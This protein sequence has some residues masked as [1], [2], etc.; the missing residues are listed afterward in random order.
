MR[1]EPPPLEG[2]NGIITGY[3]LRYRIQGKKGGNTI[4]TP[5]N[6]R[7]HTLSDLERSTKYQ[8]KLWAMN[9]NGT[10]P[11]TDWFDIET[12]E[13]DLDES[14]VPDEPGPLRGKLFNYFTTG[15]LQ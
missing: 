1:W 12:Y 5:A 15:C 3:K 10:G 14:R 8:V 6:T 11:P 7:M 2:Q 13:N 4:T 9:V